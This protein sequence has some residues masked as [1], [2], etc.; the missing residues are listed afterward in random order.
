MVN[1]S[2]IFVPYLFSFTRI[3]EL[4]NNLNWKII[5][6]NREKHNIK[7]IKLEFKWN[8]NCN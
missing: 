3:M 1:N 2:I 6:N 4:F 8:A 7:L 5:E